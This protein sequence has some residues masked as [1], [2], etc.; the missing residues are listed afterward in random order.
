MVDVNARLE[1]FA[2]V[3]ELINGPEAENFKGRYF[4]RYFSGDMTFVFDEAP[5]TLTFHKGTMIAVEFGQPL[6]GVNIGLGGKT[7]QW[8]DFFRH[9]NFQLATSPKHNPLCFKTL[10]SPLGYR[11]NN[12]TV[13]QLMR[14]M[15]KVMG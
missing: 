4:G 1:Q 5:F 14:V 12:N 7:E 3:K 8:E 9:R 11:Q 13:A 2:A 10:G 15:A 6:N